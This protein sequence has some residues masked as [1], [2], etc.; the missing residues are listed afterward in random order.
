MFGSDTFLTVCDLIESS[1]EEW[2]ISKSEANKIVDFEFIAAGDD[3][4]WGDGCGNNSVMI[5]NF[6]IINKATSKR[7][8]ACG[9]SVIIV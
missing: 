5:R 2:A 1:S 4:F 6:A 3:S 8:L 9:I 7:T